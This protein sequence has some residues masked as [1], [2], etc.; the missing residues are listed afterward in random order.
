[1]LCRFPDLYDYGEHDGDFESS[2]GMGRY[3]LM[4]SGNHLN[5]GKTPS[6][7]CAYLRD[8][9]GWCGRIPVKSA[10]VHKVSHG[11]YGT[12]HI[13]ETD[14]FN[15]YFLI[16]N[17]YRDNLDGWLPSSGLAVYHCDTLGSNEWQGGTAERHYQC[18]LIQADGHLDLERY[19][20]FGD[21]GDL[22]GAAKGTVL[23]HSTK[24]SSNLWN[25]SESGLTIQNISKPNEM[26]T[27]ETIKPS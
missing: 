24:P 3:C 23:S 12:V 8:L 22:F 15:E 11:D 13:Y 19:I 5:Q 6:P 16:E 18:G 20:N 1:M 17:R 27:L 21:E 26:I 7:I 9:A 10:K 2:A 4:S 14:N 25:G